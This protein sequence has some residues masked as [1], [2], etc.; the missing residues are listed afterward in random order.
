MS[1]GEQGMYNPPR[2]WYNGKKEVADV[3]DMIFRIWKSMLERKYDKE[4]DCHFDQAAELEAAIPPRPPKEP[5]VIPPLQER[6]DSCYESLDQLQAEWAQMDEHERWFYPM[7]EDAEL[8]EVTYTHNRMNRVRIYRERA[9]YSVHFDEL[10]LCREEL[11]QW[12]YEPGMPW[13]EWQTADP[14][15]S[16]DTLEDA[17]RIAKTILQQLT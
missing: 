2:A 1:T 3:L 8:L 13:G 11:L 17:R 9:Y 16:A 5:V 14:W 10:N 4:K 15:S 7:Q 12:I 6:I